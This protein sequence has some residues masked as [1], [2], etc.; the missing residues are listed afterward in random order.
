MTEE[1]ALEKVNEDSKDFF[2]GRNLKKVEVYFSSLPP[3]YHHLLVKRLVW[4]AAE[5]DVELVTRFFN[6]AVSKGLCSAD[7]FE[8]GLTPLAEVIIDIA[9]EAP[10]V[11]HMLAMM[12][13]GASLDERRLSNLASK[14]SDSDQ[15]FAL[16]RYVNSR[17]TY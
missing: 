17:R 10:K 12:A 9:D 4:T 5:H 1:A 14:S 13:K 8:K 2:T 6:L 3:Q 15:F 7:S 11:S 16:L